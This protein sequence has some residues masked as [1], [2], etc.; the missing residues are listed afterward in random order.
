MNTYYKKHKHIGMMPELDHLIRI[1]VTHATASASDGSLPSHRGG[2]RSGKG[3]SALFAQPP[4]VLLHESLD[5]FN[6]ARVPDSDAPES[7]LPNAYRSC[8]DNE[9]RNMNVGNS[10]NTIIK[11]D[12]NMLVYL[13]CNYLFVLPLIRCY[14]TCFVGAT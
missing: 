2:Q 5:S 11:C 12:S 6:C 9:I 8:L 14:C 13:N 3:D 10:I 7:S 4:P 1:S